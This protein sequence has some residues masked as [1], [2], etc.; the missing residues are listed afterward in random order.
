M[1]RRYEKKTKVQREDEDNKIQPTLRSFMDLRSGLKGSQCMSEKIPGSQGQG[2][3]DL[4]SGPRKGST[5]VIGE[6]RREKESGGVDAEVQSRGENRGRRKDN[7]DLEDATTRPMWQGRG[8]RLDSG[9]RCSR[10]LGTQ[11]KKREREDR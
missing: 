6:T 9:Q 10:M 7:R 5:E 1:V 4:S 11:G 8:S 2:G 3:R